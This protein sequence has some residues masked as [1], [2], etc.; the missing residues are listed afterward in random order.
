MAC[1]CITNW[2]LKQTHPI[3]GFNSTTSGD[4]CSH[5]T[6]RLPDESE[7]LTQPHEGFKDRLYLIVNMSIS[8][9]EAKTLLMRK[10]LVDNFYPWVA[11]YLVIKLIS[12]QPTYP[13]L[14]LIFIDKVMPPKLEKEIL[15]S[16]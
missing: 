6:K 12:T 8:N 4:C 16:A 9:L 3:S 15:R 13:T 5:S 1:Y 14:Y 11:N 2:C 10:I 7:V